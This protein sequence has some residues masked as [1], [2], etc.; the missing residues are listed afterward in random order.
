MCEKK[1]QMMLFNFLIIFY[2]LMLNQIF[3][4]LSTK[5]FRI[6]HKLDENKHASEFQLPIS[7]LIRPVYITFEHIIKLNTQIKTKRISTRLYLLLVHLP[8]AKSKSD[9]RRKFSDLLFTP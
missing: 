8:H 6:F 4:G 7:V 9:K 5:I 1:R 3:P 2:Y